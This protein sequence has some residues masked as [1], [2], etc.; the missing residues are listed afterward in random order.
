MSPLNPEDF[1]RLEE[2]V[3]GKWAPIFLSPLIGSP[4][5]LIIGVVAANASGIYVERA[6]ALF[7]FECLYG[8]AAET[9]VFAAEVALDDLE[10]D[11]EERG[12]RALTDPRPSFSGISVGKI[13]EGEATSLAD[14]ARTWMT[15]L[16]SLYDEGSALASWAEHDVVPVVEE[17]LPIIGDGRSG[18]KLPTLVL[19]YVINQRPG[20]ED[21]FSS[22]IQRGWRRRRQADVNSAVVD[23]AGSRLVANF[24]TLMPKRRARSVDRIKRRMFD[25]IVA[26]DK[27]SRIA[28]ERAHEMIVHRPSERDLDL[29]ARQVASLSETVVALHE[30][31]R[32]EDITLRS[33]TNVPAIGDHIL[34][35]E[36]V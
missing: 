28:F 21:F 13:Y 22:G 33:M 29:T 6:N 18:E 36:A 30:Q 24:G 34:R 31:A 26:R 27:E 20:F 4:E 2:P 25:L 19:D 8:S 17:T 35:A 3:R 9:A 32:V 10:A 14:V 1:P 7:R 16:S 5:R 12:I 23:F 11:C 15:S